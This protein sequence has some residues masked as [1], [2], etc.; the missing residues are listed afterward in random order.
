MIAGGQSLL[1]LLRLRLAYP[2]LLVDLG[3]ISD[4]RGV[5]DEGDTLLIGALTTHDEVMHDPLIAGALRAACGGGGHGS[6][7]GRAAPRHPRRIAG[8]RGP[9]R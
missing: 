9:G 1:P 2:E 6:R 4:L 5:S 3:S 7:P 8:P